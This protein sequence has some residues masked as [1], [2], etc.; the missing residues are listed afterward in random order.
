MNRI[1]CRPGSPTIAAQTIACSGCRHASTSCSACSRES[2]RR[3]SQLQ[4]ELG[5]AD[6]MGNPLDAEGFR[7]IMRF[8]SRHQYLFERCFRS[9]YFV[10]ASAFDQHRAAEGE[11]VLLWQTKMTVDADGVAMAETLNP[12]INSA[13]PYF[14]REMTEPAKVM[15]RIDREGSVEMDPIEVIETVDDDDQ[16]ERET[17]PAADD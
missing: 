11:R 16:P 8:R 12:L 5:T 7:P 6:F 3:L 4:Q 10:I 2:G 9:F 17:A 14:G 1:T 15:R 13:A